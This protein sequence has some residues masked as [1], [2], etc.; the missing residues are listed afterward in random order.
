MLSPPSKH[1]DAPAAHRSYA[2]VVAGHLYVVQADLRLLA[3]DAWLLPRDRDL[4]VTEGWGPELAERVAAHGR[5]ASWG[6]GVRAAPLSAADQRPQIWLGDTGGSGR[7]S[8][9]W[10]R[11][12]IGEFIEGVAGIPTKRNLP[13]AHEADVASVDTCKLFSE[14]P[15]F[16]ADSRPGTFQNGTATQKI[17]YL[18][19]S[20][21][22]FQQVK[23]GGI[24]RM[25][26]GKNGTLFP[27][28]A[29][30][31]Q[32]IEAASDHAAIYADINL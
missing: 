15:N 31:T 10:Y 21:E 24:F 23:G 8:F 6:A 13:L 7:E 22:L 32:P 1:E 25:G 3:C 14:H 11:V 28:Y 5:P 16:T 18:L 30:I 17:D 9:D 20:P 29:T 27:H 4:W 26:G 19:L 2:G 12:A